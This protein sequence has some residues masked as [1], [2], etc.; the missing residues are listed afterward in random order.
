MKLMITKLKR[1]TGAVPA[2]EE[3]VSRG[4]IANVTKDKDFWVP[5]PQRTELTK[6]PEKVSFTSNALVVD[7]DGGKPLVLVRKNE[8][9]LTEPAKVLVLQNGLLS[10]R[11]ELAD[12]EEFQ[13]YPSRKKANNPVWAEVSRNRG[14]WGQVAELLHDLV[15]VGRK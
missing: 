6:S 7:I 4:S 2:T 10:V 1:D 5:N 12:A 11:D 8:Q 3:T 13:S 15:V 14:I 9:G